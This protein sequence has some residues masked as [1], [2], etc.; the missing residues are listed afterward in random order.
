MILDRLNYRRLFPTGNFGNEAIEISGTLEPNED[1]MQA[2]TEL[3]EMAKSLHYS[4][5][6]DFFEQSGTQERFIEPTSNP[7]SLKEDI[8][9]CKELTVLETYRLIVKNKPEL[10]EAYDK[11]R[12]KLLNQHI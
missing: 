8:E 12:E 4:K 5:N 1:I 6:K 7:R 10:Q 9:S 3:Y 11:T 2:Y